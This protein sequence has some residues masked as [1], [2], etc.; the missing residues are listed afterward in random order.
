MKYR[1]SPSIL[2][3]DVSRLG[4]E[5]TK[6]TEAGADYIH[7]DIMDGMFVQ[8]ISFGVPVVAGIRKCVDTY[9]DVHLM[10]QE[11]VRYIRRFAEAGADGITV[12]AEACGDLGQTIAEIHACGKKA[13]VSIKPGTDIDGILPFLPRLYMVLVMT[14]E[15]GYGGQKIRRDTF[16]KIRRLR[17]Y[18]NEKGYDVD[19][20]VD[21]GVNLENLHEVL[22]AGA[23]V[24]VA[25]TKVFRGDIDRNVKDFQHI[26]Q[27]YEGKREQGGCYGC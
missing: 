19:I 2:A 4:E 21:G 27:E 1:L 26:L 15:P 8:N 9:F 14:V 12:H 16:E 7:I 18:I 23:N 13:A 11:P 17:D 22:D 25:G 6:V 24:V 5:L 20:E 10:V 3:A